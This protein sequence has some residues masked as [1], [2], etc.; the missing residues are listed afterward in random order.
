[1]EAWRHE[2]VSS[3]TAAHQEV[4]GKRPKYWVRDPTTG[5]LWL[6]KEPRQSRGVVEPAIEVLMLRLARAI[7]LPA[8][9]SRACTWSEPPP[10]VGTRR[11]I[12]VSL[13]TRQGE[14]LSLGS[15]ELRAADPSYDPEKRGLHTVARVRAVLE[16]LQAAAEEPL[17]EPF[18]KMLAFDAWTGNSDRHQENW[19]ILRLGGAAP[20]RLA[21][22]FDPAA[23]LG[24]ELDPA[25]R[26]LRPDADLADAELADYIERCPSGFGDGE[27]DKPLLTMGRV[28]SAVAA[29]PEWRAGIDG[30]LAAFGGAMDTFDEVVRH[31][32]RE[33]LPPERA[34]LA[35]RL[36]RS[37][38]HWLRAA[39][40]A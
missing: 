10:G 15:V 26:F 30:W 13:F 40:R 21:P 4:R 9:E 31:V 11:G 34:S 33:W 1:M 36:L 25:H 22:L 6:R 39:G 2:D 27:R 38:L 3:W 20:R 37:R 32:P 8:P 28:V 23:C 16:A 24:V 35:C 7:G 29:W 12:I 14:E 19:G 18:A 5:A 17:L